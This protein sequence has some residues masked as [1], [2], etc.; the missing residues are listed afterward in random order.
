LGAWKFAAMS[1]RWRVVVVCVAA[2]PAVLCAGNVAKALW[3]LSQVPQ[4]FSS[5]S[6]KDVSVSAVCGNVLLMIA[7]AMNAIELARTYRNLR[8]NRP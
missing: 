4:I 6:P 8:I 2:I 3:L 7:L 1:Q 5:D